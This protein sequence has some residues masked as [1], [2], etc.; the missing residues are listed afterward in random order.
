M[1]ANRA[2]GLA[3]TAKQITQSKVKFGRFGV[4]SN[5]IDKRVNGAV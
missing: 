1:D 5:N 3:A 4:K 2:I